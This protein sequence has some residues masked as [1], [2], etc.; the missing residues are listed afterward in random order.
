[1]TLAVTILG[2]SGIY[3]TP[4]RAASGHLVEVDGAHLWLD[5][6]AGT[7]RNLL[8]LCDYPSIGG[9]LLTHRHPDHTTDVFQA[10]HAR[11]YGQAEPLSPIPLWA[12][13]ETVEA[14]QNYS[15]EISKSFD[16]HELAEDRTITF[17]GA[18]VSFVRMAHPPVTFGVRIEHRGKVFAYSA[19]SGLDADFETLTRGADLFVCEATFQDADDPW[20]GHL[21]ASQAGT[22]AA[23]AEVARLV[24]T[25]L[26]PGRDHVRTLTEAQEAAG[27]IPVELAEDRRRFDL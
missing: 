1:M 11:Q 9:V 2:S 18:T 23:K 6:G 20:T 14:L 13:A 12:P 22:L 26:P 27:S 5:A 16:L 7:W 15:P 24:L 8:T 17:N 21:S 19:D 4:T 25:H 10:L 3:G